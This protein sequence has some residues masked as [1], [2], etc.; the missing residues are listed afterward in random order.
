MEPVCWSVWSMCAL[1]LRAQLGK[2]LLGCVPLCWCGHPVG[3]SQAAMVAAWLGLPSPQ[4]P[5]WELVCGD[6]GC[7]GGVFCLFSRDVVAWFVL[8]E[9]A[10]ES[11]RVDCVQS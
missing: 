3:P 9:D 6:V 2:G 1:G 5:G 7:G 10:V 8:V 11:L 4:L